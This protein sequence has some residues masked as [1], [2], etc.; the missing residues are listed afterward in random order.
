MDPSRVR[1]LVLN[2]WHE[3]TIV[4]GNGFEMIFDVIVASGA[5]VVVLSEVINRE[6][7]LHKRLAVAL[8]KRGMI[9]HGAHGA[10]DV[11]LMSRWPIERVDHVAYTIVAY[12][13]RT[14]QPLCVCAAHLDYRNYAP[15]LPRGYNASVYSGGTNG[16]SV[17]H[18]R[19]DGGEHVWF[20]EEFNGA[21]ASQLVWDF[22][23]RHN[24]QGA[25]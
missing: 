12:H 25:L 6:G 23:T 4:P 1:L 17:E 20:S 19:Y 11:T 10:G 16:V 22:T 14:P 21:N 13:L 15:V 5:N 18:Y 8:R 2:T 9:F 24:L 3:G 7:K